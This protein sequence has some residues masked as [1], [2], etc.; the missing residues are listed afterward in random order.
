MP[1]QPEQTRLLVRILAA[2]GGALAVAGGRSRGRALQILKVVF[3]VFRRGISQ[4]QVFLGRMKYLAD[5][6]MR[7]DLPLQRQ[8][9]LML[10]V[11]LVLFI[12]GS[13]VIQALVVMPTFE[14]LE[15]EKASRDVDRCMTALKRDLES[16]GDLTSNWGAWDDICEFVQNRN[17]GFEE[18]NLNK[19]VF[20]SAR[21]SLIALLDTNRNLVW[22]ECRDIHKLEPIE[23]PELWPALAGPAF[24]LTRHEHVEDSRGGL[25][26]TGLGPMLLHASPVITSKMDGPVR[27]SV[28]MGRFLGRKEVAALGDRCGVNL[29]AWTVDELPRE[30]LRVLEELRRTGRPLVRVEGATSMLAFAKLDDLHQG[31]GL[32]LRVRVP[33]E[34]T[35]RGE[36]AGIVATCGGILGSLAVTVA[37]GILI[38]RRIVT[39]LEAIVAHARHIGEESNLKARL[40]CERGDEIGQ[41][42]RAFDEMV[43]CLA[44]SR[45]RVLGAAHQAGMAD[46]TSEVLHNVGNVIN[47]ANASVEQLGE[48]LHNS[49]VSGLE[50]AVELLRENSGRIGEFFSQDPRGPKLADYLMKISGV[51]RQECRANLERVARIRKSLFH[52]Q[53]IISHQEQW[54]HRPEFAFETDLAEVFQEVL[55]LNQDRLDQAGI[56]TE[57]QVEPKLELMLNKSKLTQV[58]VN[59]VRNAIQAMERTAGGARVLTLLARRLDD[60][61][62]EIEIQDTGCGMT[63]EVQASLFHHGFTTKENSQGIGLHYCANAVRTMGGAIAASSGGPGRGASIRIRLPEPGRIRGAEAA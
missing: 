9:A 29:T 60:Q 50:R 62:I 16:L 21:V 13:Y 23:I 3:P 17:P 26:L 14:S 40:N 55:L 7:S 18:A 24:P 58:L 63:D 42:S 48:Q 39:P 46:V 43:G 10:A 36:F 15:R 27:G 30:E 41:L 56:V 35:A 47:S 31:P 49:K 19:E 1:N 2:I 6:I 5:S 38:Q 22:G 37:A 4:V 54:A 33:R 61:S 28:V 12:A 32:L 8:L 53:E 51:M 34:V 44:T 59:L 11:M 57:L 25:L 52:I 20:A 45:K